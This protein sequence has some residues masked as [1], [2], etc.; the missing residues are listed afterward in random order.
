[1]P[2]LA[3]PG[4]PAMPGSALANG[5]HGIF[6]ISSTC[7]AHICVC[8]TVMMEERSL[9]NLGALIIDE[10][11]MLADPNRW[12]LVAHTLSDLLCIPVRPG[13][14]LMWMKH[15]SSMKHSC[16]RENGTYGTWP[17]R[18]D[19][20]KICN[21][22]FLSLSLFQ[23]LSFGTL[24]D[25]AAL[26]HLH[27]N[28]RWKEAQKELKRMFN[29]LITYK[30]DHANHMTHVLLAPSLCASNLW[31]ACPWEMQTAQL[32]TSMVSEM[33]SKL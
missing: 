17:W 5:S 4:R 20:K 19:S 24:V 23:G 29:T 30:L 7:F 1:M 3:L 18:L 33:E 16:S 26:L 8:T 31:C 27:S 12:T 13:Q 15:S 14:P 11:H 25:Q 22:V 9:C 6:W 10:L 21:T 32:R 2:G 28:N